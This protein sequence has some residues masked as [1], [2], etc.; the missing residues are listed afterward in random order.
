MGFIETLPFE[1]D[2][3]DP[4]DLRQR[5]TPGVRAHRNHESAEVCHDFIWFR[6]NL[7]KP[8]YLLNPTTGEKLYVE[9]YSA[10]F[11]TVNQYHGGDA[12]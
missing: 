4:V 8:F 9:G 3:P 5:R 11:D 2:R 1:G 12:T 6:T 7:R 10:W